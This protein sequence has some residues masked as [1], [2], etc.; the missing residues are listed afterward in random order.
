MKILYERKI[1]NIIYNFLS[2]DD[3]CRLKEYP[4]YIVKELK[5]PSWKYSFNQNNIKIIRLNKSNKLNDVRIFLKNNDN[6]FYH[7]NDKNYYVSK[8]IYMK[9]GIDKFD[10]SID[11]I[12]IE[13]QVEN[14]LCID[15]LKKCELFRNPYYITIDEIINSNY[16]KLLGYIIYVYFGEIDVS[17]LLY[18]VNLTDEEIIPL[19]KRMCAIRMA[20]HT[21]KGYIIKKIKKNINGSICYIENKIDSLENSILK[22]DFPAVV[23][24]IKEI[25]MIPTAGNMKL[26]KKYLPQL[27]GPLDLLF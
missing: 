4:N 11:E 2:F 20:I 13:I 8:K 14:T 25:G 18:P 7:N 26:I 12:P 19:E 15:Y 17:Y 23:F 10:N 3:F 24:L 16:I 27:E 9:Y 5:I 22:K 1:L 21:D 6:N